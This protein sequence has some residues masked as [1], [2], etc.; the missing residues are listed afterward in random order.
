MARFLET[1]RETYDFVI[2]DSPPI[3]AVS[4]AILPASRSDGVVLC[5][6]A[7]TIH[8]EAVTECRQ[9]LALADIKILGAVFNRQRPTGGGYYKSSYHYDQTYGEPSEADSAA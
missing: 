8:R 6:R 3:L 7:N 5:F 2:V 9:R 4:D 1:M